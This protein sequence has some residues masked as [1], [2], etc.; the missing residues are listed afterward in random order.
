MRRF[1]R[2]LSIAVVLA[3]LGSS[4]SGSMSVMGAENSGLGET[5]A[6]VEEAGQELLDTETAAPE[7]PDIP[8]ES[9]GHDMDGPDAATE[10]AAGEEAAYDENEMAGQEDTDPGQE[11]AAQ[12]PQE[13]EDLQDRETEEPADETLPQEG[14]TQAPA[15]LEEEQ[16]PPAKSGN[17]YFVL[18]GEGGVLNILD[19]EGSV[20]LSARTEEDSLSLEDLYG[21]TAR[22]TADGIEILDK[23]RNSF[24]TGSSIMLAEGGFFEVEQDGITYVAEDGALKE[25]PEEEKASAGILPVSYENGSA[26]I[27][28]TGE[29]NVSVSYN[30]RAGEGFVNSGYEIPSGSDVSDN[31]EA[32]AGTAVFSGDD[33]DAG[34]TY[35]FSFAEKTDEVE[36]EEKKEE[37]ED[38]ITVQTQEQV[39]SKEAAGLKISESEYTVT[40]DA[41]G[42][43]FEDGSETN[44]MTYHIPQ[45]YVSKTSNLSE[46]G[47]V[48]LESYPASQAVTDTVTIEGAEKLYVTITYQTEGTSYDWVC[49]YDGTVTPSATNYNSSISKKLGGRIK[50]TSTFEVPGDTAKFFFRSDASTN[51]FYGYYATVS[52]EDYVEFSLAEGEYKEPASGETKKFTQWNTAADGS[53][54]TIKPEEYAGWQDITLYAQYRN[55]KAPETHAVTFDANGG[56]FE[57]GS[58]S[59]TVEYTVKRSSSPNVDENGTKTG[60]YPNNYEQNDVITIENAENLFI[61]IKYNTESNDWTCIYDSGTTPSR[62][63]YS[64]SLSKKLSGSGTKEYAVEGNA[65]QIFFATNGTNNNYYGYYADI[66]GLSSGS[67]LVPQKENCAFTGWN[68]SPDGTGE[69]VDPEKYVWEEDTTLYAQYEDSIVGIL[70]EDGTYVIKTQAAPIED[71]TAQHGQ[72]VETYADIKHDFGPLGRTRKDEIKKIIVD[73]D[74]KPEGEDN[75]AFTW[76]SNH[77]N[78]TEIE[79]IDRVDTSGITNMQNAFA[80]DKKLTELDLNSWD[81][82]GVTDLKLAF[83]ECA[84]LKKLNI[85]GWDTSSVKTLEAAFAD[86]SSLTVLNIGGWDIKNV[87]SL[88]ATFFG[89]SS[90][91]TLNVR[92]WDT[93]KVTEIGSA[94]AGCTG[95]TRLDLS[96]WN[97]SAVTRA[98]AP[99]GNCSGLKMLNINGWDLSHIPADNSSFTSFFASI[100]CNGNSASLFARNMKIPP[101]MTTLPLYSL[102]F[103]NADLS[104]WNV[105][106]VKRMSFN[107]SNDLET[108]VVG[109]WNT[110]SLENLDGAFAAIRS[111]RSIIGIE[112]FN[113]SNLKSAS[114]AFNTC[115][116]LEKID[117]SNWDTS[118]LEN[119]SMMFQGCESLES[120]KVGTWNT[121]SLKNMSSMF[122]SC[123]LRSL[124]LSNWDTSSVTNMS[125]FLSYVPTIETLTLGENFV[126]K[127][128]QD[129]SGAR[130]S[131]TYPGWTHVDTG[132]TVADLWNGYDAENLPGT[133][134]RTSVLTEFSTE[135]IDDIE[136][137]P[138]SGEITVY[139]DTDSY[140]HPA[141][142]SLPS[143]WNLIRVHPE[144]AAE[145][146]ELKNMLEDSV[147]NGTYENLDLTL[148]LKARTYAD[149]SSCSYSG[150]FI[151]TFD[152]PENNETVMRTDI[153]ECSGINK[154]YK[155]YIVNSEED[156][157]TFTVYDVSGNVVET[158]QPGARH[159]YKDIGFDVQDG[160]QYAV[161][162]GKRVTPELAEEYVYPEYK[163]YISYNKFMDN[164]E[165][166]M[167]P[168]KYIFETTTPS[169]VGL[170][171]LPV[172]QGEDDETNEAYTFGTPAASEYAYMTMFNEIKS[173]T[174]NEYRT[175]EDSYGVFK[176]L[177]KKTRSPV[178]GAVYKFTG[179]TTGD[180]A[181]GITRNGEIEHGQLYKTRDLSVYYTPVLHEVYIAEEVTA[182]DGYYLSPEKTEIIFWIDHSESHVIDYN[183]MIYSDGISDTQKGT[184]GYICTTCRGTQ[185]RCLC[186]DYGSSMCTNCG[187]KQNEI[188]TEEQET[189]CYDQPKPR[190]DV[191]KKGQIGNILN[192]AVLQL[193]NKETGA[194]I[195]EWI[196][197]GTKHMHTFTDEEIAY[198]QTGKIFII[199]EKTPPANYEKADDIEVTMSYDSGNVSKTMIDVYAS[200]EVIISKTDING[201]EIDGA[202]L[203]V[204]GR[205]TGASADI[206]PIQWVSE[207]GK[208]RTINLK[209]G[210]YTLHEE[211]VPEGGVY[212]LASDIT[213]TVDINGNVKVADQDVDKVTMID[214]YAPHEVIISKTDIN[215]HEIDGAQLEIT[216]RETGAAGDITPIQWVSEEGKDRT[217]NLRPGTYTLHERAVPEGGVYVLASDITFT[218]D[219][220]GNVKVADQDVDKVTMIDDYSSSSLKIKKTVSGNM[221]DRNR[222]F[223]FTVELKNA[224]NTPYTKQVSYTK[225]NDSGILT[226]N[227]N[228]NITFSLAHGEEIEMLDIVIGTKYTV[229]EN[230]Y[231]SEGYT[232]SKVN[233][234]GTITVSNAMVQFT[235]SRGGTIPAGI[236]ANPL[237]ALIAIIAAGSVILVMYKKRKC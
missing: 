98:Q 168:G 101:S 53:G 33:M 181:Y 148:T 14:D 72:V 190:L 15:S 163:D 100:G 88:Y 19:A 57:N 60:P 138:D 215:G 211:A 70:F 114:S 185:G 4:L 5:A 96:G 2:F 188:N 164:Y 210:A 167:A 31:G 116:G 135:N 189:V 84:A 97:T 21:D 109:G 78:L 139:I 46:R 131:L 45:H 182:P 117:L 92:N 3:M 66:V 23:D 38:G 165:V 68:T 137:D 230:D 200:H 147:E 133:Y 124:D 80:N 204:T 17:V 47:E 83:A 113:T 125:A 106:N 172:P 50:K 236:S 166:A 85:G 127:S 54:Q 69:T 206:A 11:N 43:T 187:T 132:T 115:S 202:Q 90:L 237:W 220:N 27:G 198:A 175:T 89:C 18:D 25:M 56:T 20:F 16:L 153:Y 7:E 48:L 91:K 171:L 30:I 86:C 146:E 216:G 128:G 214:V 99:F 225:G 191:T 37:K 223:A 186:V 218:V 123:K 64:A 143:I 22:I 40:F 87:T 212:V 110:Q 158:L 65:A 102:P 119:T 192:G 79:N 231:S 32:I 235:N 51:S 94:F 227:E 122:M 229:I 121:E 145:N 213:F 1:N 130:H 61:K 162:N 26:V 41:N 93:R 13:T 194:V 82:S 76:F 42:E 75:T 159:K 150:S 161:I 160:A 95:L 81:V 193:V 176:K 107:G 126:F 58:A 177:D 71:Y 207:E 29:E 134:K 35:S 157:K 77:E 149:I 108:L 49:V 180:I 169:A 152:V 174:M 24:F 12:K 170:T 156:P 34:N 217:V 226:P 179:L 197:D 144:L 59:N 196:S 221:G 205:E 154:I 63:N 219:I 120:V 55:V 155:G 228:G 118:K 232:T 104:G 151:W 28:L 224:D 129:I 62:D 140:M 6:S 67:C 39:I 208:D 36:E 201:H 10:G 184:E 52:A 195:D 105:E 8:E 183:P 199:R 112:N 142:I 173:S 203:K 73:T 74:I 9:V 141:E 103:K 178:D 222:Q 209:P 44:S 233:E 234:T 111:L 136:F